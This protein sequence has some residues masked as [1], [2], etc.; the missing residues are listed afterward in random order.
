MGD[1]T[2]TQTPYNTGN[3]TVSGRIIWN[4]PKTG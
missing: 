1:K 2:L 4:D 3:K